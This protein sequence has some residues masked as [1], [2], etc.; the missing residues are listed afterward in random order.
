MLYS[1][2]YFVKHIY[3]KFI[4]SY[5]IK[6]GLGKCGKNVVLGS[7]LSI[8][9]IGNIYIGNNSSIGGN[10]ILLTTKAKIIIGDHVMIAPHVCIVTG[11]HRIDVIGRYMN[12]IMDHEKREEDDKDVIFEG[13]N[14]VGLGSIILKG[15]HVGIGAVI[16]AGSVVT[17]DVPP[18]ALVC[19]NPAK[20]IKMRFLEEEIIKH[21]EV[22]KNYL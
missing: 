8:S 14:W 9:G 5:I 12:T 22:I 13:D 20:V 21:K 19:G 17:K 16:G 3:V 6:S 2:F 11:N 4:Y 7:N 10:C 15:V 18:Y 1:F